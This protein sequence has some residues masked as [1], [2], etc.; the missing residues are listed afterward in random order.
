MSIVVNPRVDKLSKDLIEAYKKLAPATL[1]HILETAMVPEIQ[2]VY[3]PIKLVGPAITVQTYPQIAS[4]M[5]AAAKIARPGD[6]LVVARGDDRRHGTTGEIGSYGYMELG[7]AGLV[8]DGPIADTV[9]ITRMKFPVYSRGAV[10][11]TGKTGGWG[12]EWG[13]VNVP[14]NVGGVVVNPGDMVFGDEDG[15][16]IASPEEAKQHL[17]FVQEKEEWEAWVRV[18]VLEKGRKLSDLQKER[19]DPM[20]KVVV[21]TIRR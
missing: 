10:A 17:A 12:I 14:V 19:P 16:L 4:A 3:R 21:G 18:Q 11:M 5:A 13:A 7:I 9:A 1:G 20:K 6:V 2:P 8:T 15:V